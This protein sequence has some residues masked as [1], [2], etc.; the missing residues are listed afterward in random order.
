MSDAVTDL[1]ARVAVLERIAADTA[2][3]L[4]DLRDDLREFRA[5]IRTEL[6]SEIGGLRTE[7]RAELRSEIGGVRS[8]LAEQRG[9]LRTQ[10]YWTLGA[11]LGLLGVMAHGF[12]WL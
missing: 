7:L 2:Q 10:F 12:H 8:E 5:E 11:L 6:R 3:G 1:T 9:A 4:R